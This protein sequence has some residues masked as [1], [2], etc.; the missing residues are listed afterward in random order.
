MNIMMF[1]ILLK[2]KT[3]TKIF[4]NLDY[5]NW[6]YGAVGI[7]FVRVRFIHLS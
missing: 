1:N 6:I 2:K 5:F 3:M 7:A 4:C